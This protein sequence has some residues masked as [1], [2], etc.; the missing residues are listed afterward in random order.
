M[1]NKGIMIQCRG[2]LERLPF[3]RT[4]VGSMPVHKCEVQRVAG[5]VLLDTLLYADLFQSAYY[6]GKVC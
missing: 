3:F 6:G 1:N 5:P 4:S 2:I